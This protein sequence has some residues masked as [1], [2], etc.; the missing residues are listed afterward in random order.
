MLVTPAGQTVELAY[1]ASATIRGIVVGADGE[2]V[3]KAHVTA[4]F[5]RDART[6]VTDAKGRFELLVPK[7]AAN[8]KLVARKLRGS[9]WRQSPGEEASAG[10]E[11]A[12]LVLPD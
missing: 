5:D 10:T 3:G 7:G 4:A 2:P 1:R 6:A 9:R 8:V 12:R 11:N